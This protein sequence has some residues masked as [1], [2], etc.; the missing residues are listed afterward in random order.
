M[1]TRHNANHA[2]AALNSLI[3]SLPRPKQGGFIRYISREEYVCQL[4]E[5]EFLVEDIFDLHNWLDQLDIPE[6][7]PETGEPLDLK[8]RFQYLLS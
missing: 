3:E 4:R 7:D 2:Q 1:S 8:G 6:T 5:M